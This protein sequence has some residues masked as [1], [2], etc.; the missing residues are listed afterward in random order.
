[1]LEWNCLRSKL[2]SIGD[3]SVESETRVVGSRFNKL[4]HADNEGIFRV[5]LRILPLVLFSRP[6]IGDFQI[7]REWPRRQRTRVEREGDFALLQGDLF[8][9]SPFVKVQIRSLALVHP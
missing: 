2:A 7:C 5:K 1:M 3:R 8:H 6:S 9:E 4:W